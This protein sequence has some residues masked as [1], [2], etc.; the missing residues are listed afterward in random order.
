MLTCTPTISFLEQP[1][2]LDLR[3]EMMTL[4]RQIGPG[5]MMNTAYDTAWVARL[6]KLGEPMAEEALDWLREHQL[7]DGSWGAE[8]PVYHHDRVICT[9]AAAIALA[10]RGLAEDR[11]R[12]ERAMKALD[13]HQTWLHLDPA[14]ETVAFEMLLPTL[15][16]E[17]KVLRLIPRGGTAMLND[18]ARTRETKLAKAP[19]R[20]I[21]RYTTMAHSTEMVGQDALHLLD[22][23]NLQE[24]N[25]S[26][27]HSPSATAFFTLHVWPEPKALNYLSTN[28]ANGGVPDVAPFDIFE[29]AWTLW[30]LALSDRNDYKMLNMCRRHLNF[31]ETS[32]RVENG[33][34]FAA[35]YSCRDGDDSSLVFEVLGRY[36]HST[37]LSTILQYEEEDHFRCFALESNPSISTNIHVLGA[38]R[39]AGL[40]AKHPSIQK[41]LTF[42]RRQKTVQNYWIDKWHASP[43]YATAHL[44]IA[45]AGYYNTLVEDAIEWIVDTQNVDGSWGHYSATAEETA[46]SLQALAIWRQSGQSVPNSTLKRGT[47]WLLEHTEPPYPPLWI[48]KCLYSP[49][50]VVRS[51]ILSALM[52]N[53]YTENPLNGTYPELSFSC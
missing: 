23:E 8:Q 53:T 25:G 22:I 26:I 44:I 42:L 2:Q 51:A 40:P 7:A 6:H 31:L 41:I 46:Y 36:G 38:L 50:L 47:A 4:L 12:V 48:G 45:C 49:T 11:V 21:S 28:M 17:A 34:G 33:V 39:L 30:N 1:Q 16:A 14:G 24:S 9:L 37:N 20:L 15:I 32:W 19:G 52:L 3:Q 5:H 13:K 10:E 18:M 35:D 27:G 29:P 43:Y